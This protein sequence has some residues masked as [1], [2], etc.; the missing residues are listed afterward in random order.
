MHHED[1]IRLK[2]DS[3]YIV[4]DNNLQSNKTAKIKTLLMIL[5]AEFFYTKYT[6]DQDEDGINKLQ[7]LGEEIYKYAEMELKPF[8]KE[9]LKSVLLLGNLYFYG[10]KDNEK[11][12]KFIEDCIKYAC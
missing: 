11:A 10:L 6:I 12:K 7:T 2:I 8:E 5:K 3:L 4:F 9:Y 1:D